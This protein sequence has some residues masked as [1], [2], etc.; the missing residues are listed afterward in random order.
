MVTDENTPPKA[1]TLGD[2]Q[3]ASARAWNQPRWHVSPLVELSYLKLHE[4]HTSRCWSRI[5]RPQ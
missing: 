4:R 2:K 1:K 3:A 5:T